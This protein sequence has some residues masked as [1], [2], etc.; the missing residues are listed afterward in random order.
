[1]DFHTIIDF[2]LHTN[3]Y[4]PEIMAQYQYWIYG[5]LFLIIFAETGLVVAPFLPGDSLLFATGA[6]AAAG[7]TERGASMSIAILLPLLI[8]AAV[9]GDTLNYHIGKWVGPKVFEKDNRFIKRKYLLAAQDF[10]EKNG[11]K[12]IIMAR[13]APF[14]RTFAPFVAGIGTMNYGKFIVYNLIGGVAWIST[15]LLL[16]YWVGNTQIVKDNFGIINISIILLSITPIF[17][18]IFQQWKENNSK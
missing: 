14:V 1:M 13:F 10:Y 6:L 4:L 15:F 17:Y 18:Q 12:A 7:S 11:G 8:V 2:V 16:G 3:K 9:L 5:I